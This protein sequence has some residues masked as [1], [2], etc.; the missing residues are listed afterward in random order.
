MNVLI[1][2]G[3]GFIG[4]NLAIALSS[5]G[6]NVTVL[7]KRQTTI[8]NV[9]LHVC[10][11]TTIPHVALL[12]ILN[13]VDI[14]YHLACVVGVKNYDNRVATSVITDNLIDNKIIAAAQETSKRL[15]YTSSS[16]VYNNC[17]DATEDDM[18][19][20]GSPS[21]HLRWGYACNK[22]MTEFLLKCNNISE[23]VVRPFNIT[24]SGHS[25]TTGMVLPRFIHSAK[26][27]KDITLYGDGEQTR[28]L[29]DIRDAINMLTCV[30]ADAHVG[31]TYNIGN[32]TNQIT[33]KN[34]AERVIQLTGS[35]SKIKYVN[36]SKVFNTDVPD[37]N[38]RTPN[39]N[40]IKKYY[41]PKYGI[42]QII[43]SMI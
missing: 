14:V 18:L 11:L 27:N 16:E 9:N 31:M 36:R 7:D 21:N 22:L 13:D 17:V 29:C 24:G 15:I 3:A 34:L 43:E 25:S 39:I 20:I 4:K 33:I 37:I 12:N 41:T 6:H 42:N 38:T 23:T 28:S 8:E 19:T 30:S 26:F 2:G 35:R 10:D 40:K 1:T 32:D 5:Q